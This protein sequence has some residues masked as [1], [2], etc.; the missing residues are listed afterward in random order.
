VTETPCT[1]W[2][3]AQWE[4]WRESIRTLGRQGDPAAALASCDELLAA[5]PSA[6]V[7]HRTVVVLHGKAWALRTLGRA[8]EAA[9]CDEAALRALQATGERIDSS[10]REAADTAW[11]RLFAWACGPAEMAYLLE[12]LA[13]CHS[14]GSEEELELGLMFAEWARLVDGRQEPGG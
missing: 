12:G 14:S 3:E 4:A 7:D 6:E 8:D 5:L 2:D 10:D 9:E 11:K 1:E 13:R